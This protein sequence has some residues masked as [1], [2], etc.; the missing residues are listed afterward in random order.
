V[1]NNEIS[2]LV[3]K[4]GDSFVW[5]ERVRMIH[6][7]KTKSSLIKAEEREGVKLV[8]IIKS[9]CAGVGN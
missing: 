4:M 2:N 1:I 5:R 9:D 7:G 3:N 6:K 8:L